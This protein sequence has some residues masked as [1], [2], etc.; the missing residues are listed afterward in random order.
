MKRS[1][2]SVAAARRVIEIDEVLV[3]SIASGLQLTGRAPVKILRLTASF[4]VA[5]SITRSQSPRSSRSGAGL[6]RVERRLAVGL[7]DRALARPGG[8][9]CR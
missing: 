1:G 6:M 7:V 5:A 8:P 3:A 4:S 9:C 2:R